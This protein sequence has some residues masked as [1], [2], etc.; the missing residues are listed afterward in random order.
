MTVYQ[1]GWLLFGLMIA[2]TVFNARKKLPFL[3]L[4]SARA[5]LQ[6]HIWMGFVSAIVFF[7]HIG[8]RMPSGWFNWVFTGL[9]AAVMVSGIIGFVWSRTIPQRLTARG[10][11]IIWEQ[12]PARRA[13][14]RAEAESVAL[15]S[16]A[17][18]KAETVAQFYA[19]H[20][21]DYF[22]GAQDVPRD[23]LA[24]LENL[25]RV[26]N[27]QERAVADKLASLILEKDNLDFHYAQQFRLKAW[28]FVHIPLTYSLLVF[29]V[30]HI[31]VVYAFSGGA[32]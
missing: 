3:P 23:L 19:D 15:R 4:F 20:L 12:I 14:V 24:K 10:G 11:E 8:W 27:E 29:S 17:E 2:L 28:L 13:A 31:V 6:F 30:M 1:T 22:L 21:H 5:W 18:A 16:V 26:L 32:R 9:Y 25:K 7:W